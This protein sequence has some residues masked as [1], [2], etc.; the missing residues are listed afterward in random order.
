MTDE[1]PILVSHLKFYRKETTKHLVNIRHIT[2]QI[3][4]AE[5]N[6]DFFGKVKYCNECGKIL[7]IKDNVCPVCHKYDNVIENT[8]EDHIKMLLRS[9]TDKRNL[10]NNI[11]DELDNFEY[12]GQE[13]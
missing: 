2:K 11:M 7:L 10:F 9:L 8:L 3:E 4:E 1:I 13:Y 5:R 6:L 12:K